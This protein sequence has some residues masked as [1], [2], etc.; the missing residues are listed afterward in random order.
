MYFYD[1]APTSWV[2]TTAFLFRVLAYAAVSPIIVLTLLDITAYVIARTI[3]ATSGKTKARVVTVSA[4]TTPTISVSETTEVSTLDG[5]GASNGLGHGSQLSASYPSDS[6]H[7]T[8]EALSGT[9]LFSP[10]QSRPGSPGV[11]RKRHRSESITSGDI[12]P[13]SIL[14]VDENEDGS[15]K[16][17]LRKRNVGVAPLTSL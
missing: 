10:P 8:G 4:G 15:E 11:Q 2:A 1:P 3:G 5:S 9:G 12:N 16:S 17:S 7:H 14:E 13:A 6:F